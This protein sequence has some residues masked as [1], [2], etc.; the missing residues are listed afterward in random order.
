MRDTVPQPGGGAAA[1][2]ERGGGDGGWEV[3]AYIDSGP[4]RT[5]RSYEFTDFGE[6]ASGA[7][8]AAQVCEETAAATRCD[9][10]RSR[11]DAAG[12]SVRLLAP[13][14]SFRPLI[15]QRQSINS[16][17]GVRRGWQASACGWNQCVLR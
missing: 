8:Y 5:K 10:L 13:R 16:G 6:Q 3:V 17:H 15:E 9:S 14:R 4:P 11:E 12:R 2:P 7:A 1:G